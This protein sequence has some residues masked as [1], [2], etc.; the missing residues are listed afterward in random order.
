MQFIDDLL[1]NKQC[2]CGRPLEEGSDSLVKVASYKSTA[3]TDDIEDAFIKTSG[4]V[5]HMENERQN[6]IVRT[7]EFQKREKEIKEEI[8][9]LHEEIDEIDKKFGGSDVEDI[10]KLETKREEAID[11]IHEFSQKIGEL[12]LKLDQDGEDLEEVRKKRKELAAKDMAAS[13]IR[14]KLELAEEVKNITDALLDAL[15]DSVRKEL[16]KKVNE[17]FRSILVKNYWAEISEDYTLQIFK[18]VGDYKHLVSDKSTGESQVSSLSFIGSIVALA[19]ERHE[20][21]AG[22]YKGG[23]YPI[24]MD[25]PYGNLDP[26]YREK[27]AKYIPQLAEQVIVMATNSQ[28]R[29]EVEDA[30]QAI[31]GKEYSLIYHTPHKK[32]GDETKLILEDSDYEYTE[33]KEGYYD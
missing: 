16:S 24:V 10:V 11:K 5:S 26:E 30:V 20:Q 3:N 1:S 19:K 29:G 7:K 12:K 9:K 13:S 21:N 23:V 6:L 28:W 31:K 18:K 2:I 15:S 8:Q 32:S 22:Y 25:S 4:S 27:V 33:I 14:Q 17:T